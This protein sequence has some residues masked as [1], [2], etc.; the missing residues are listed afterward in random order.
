MSVL[1]AEEI[2]ETLREYFSGSSLV[3]EAELRL[4]PQLL[5]QLKIYLDLLVRWN[6]RTNLSAI[7][8]PREI[9]RRHFG[10]SLF[11]AS[12][13]RGEGTL[14]DF[15]SGA[16]F[17][18]LPIQLWWPGLVVTLAESQGKKAAFLREV[19]RSLGIQVEVWSRRVEE[20][21]EDC[22]FDGVVMRAVDSPEL[23]LRVALTRMRSDL[24]L[25][26]SE[27]PVGLGEMGVKVA[28]WAGLPGAERTFLFQIVRM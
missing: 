13:V 21:P 17:P 2:G 8:E 28:E 7:R 14:L 18:G 15:G 20:M 16:G 6:E 23:A 19:G 1:S 24:W 25:L 3:W 4:R 11:A 10:E 22:V 9:V 27:E 26:A 12:F 5:E